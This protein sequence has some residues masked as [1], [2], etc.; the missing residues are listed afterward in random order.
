MIKVL[1]IL[2]VL[3][4]VS[5]GAE[6][7]SKPVVR[8]IEG[9]RGR[10][11]SAISHYAEEKETLFRPGTEFET[12]RVDTRATTVHVHQR[13]VPYSHRPDG[14]D[15]PSG[16]ILITGTRD[17]PAVFANFSGETQRPGRADAAHTSRFGF[18]DL[19]ARDEYTDSSGR[20]ILTDR[21]DPSRPSLA[22]VASGEASGVSVRE[23]MGN[24]YVPNVF[25]SRGTAAERDALAD[26]TTTS[27]CARMNGL[28]RGSIPDRGSSRDV[29][30]VV[31]AISGLNKTPP[32]PAT[33]YRGE[34][35]YP[36][37]PDFRP[38]SRTADSGFVSSSRSRG[39]ADSFS[40]GDSSSGDGGGSS[41][42][43]Q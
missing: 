42:S 27:G 2:P 14:T 32:A 31:D 12:T 21:L 29:A 37:R 36:G 38:G 4:M 33:S 35:P 24:T 7:G 5:F 11:V 1:F 41:C 16:P 26:Y 10:D 8:H 30:S 40:G 19:G 18:S 17:R 23:A 43:V 6:D 15:L 28:L 22:D 3:S 20:P 39:V 13:E 25:S 34:H 9:S